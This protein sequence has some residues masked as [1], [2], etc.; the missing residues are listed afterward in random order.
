MSD[1]VD[2]QLSEQRPIAMPVAPDQ[3]DVAILGGGMA[4][5]TLALQLKKTRPST[6]ILVVE[7]QKHPVPE[8]AHK[9]GESTV[10]IAAH[11]LRDVLGLEEHLHTQQLRKFGLRMFFSA[12]GNQDITRRVEFGQ[13]AQAPLE[14]YQLD[15]GRLEN[16]LGCELQQQGITFLD[17]CSVQQV[18]LQH[19]AHA[20]HLLHEEKVLTVQ[21][22][23]V[24]DASGRRSLLKRQLGLAKPVAH[25]A[26][27]VWFRVGRTIDI[28]DWSADPQ[29]RDLLSPHRLACL[30]DTNDWSAK[31]Q[32]QYRVLG[33]ERSL[34]TNHLMGPGYWVWLIRLASDSTSIGIVT[35]AAMHPFEQINR[36]ER[37]LAWLQSHEPQCAAVIEQHRDEIL[38]FRVMKNYAYSSQ[39]VYS[40]QRWCLTGEAAV[41]LDPLYSSGGDLIAIGNGLICDLINRELEGEDIQIRAVAHNQIFLILVEVWLGLYYQQYRLMGNAQV[42]VAKLIWDTAVY[43]GGPGLLYFHD[44][45]CRMMDN[46]GIALSFNRF[47]LL[48]S[49]V[50]AFFREWHEID[51]PAISDKFVE[52][53]ILLDFLVKL[54]VGMAAGLPDA[55]LE[56]Q[57]AANVRLFER[58]AGEMVSKVMEGY[59]DQSENEAALNQLQRWRADAFLMELVAIYQQEEQDNPI[60]SSW[61]N[62]AYQG[63]YRQEVAR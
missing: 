9:V 49:I 39:Q 35:D 36:L 38:D 52:P 34:S 29:W 40:G 37:A 25:T 63:G 53:Y 10:E 61:I 31:P 43:W 60:D 56:A 58:L 15:R 3:Y 20:L 42:M 6:R 17:S 55:E 5:L 18:S 7:K 33:G 41:S 14:A 59:A 16:A 45:F 23:W 8:A 28:N 24:V 48:H 22:R 54:H 57:F 46:P 44:K 51:Q 2:D 13:I 12:E 30:I 1:V 50:Q 4:G 47:I 27:A 62:L 32:G 21:A 19:D 11:Y 26:N